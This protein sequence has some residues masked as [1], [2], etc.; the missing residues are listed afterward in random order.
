[1]NYQPDIEAEISF[2]S[3]NKGGRTQPVLS[4]YRPNHLI[5][6]NYLTSGE[7]NYID[8]VEVQPGEKSRAYIKFIAPEEYP[9]TLRVGTIINVQE[10]NRLIG[11]AK[12]L[13]IFNKILEKTIC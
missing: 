9:Y 4:G 7:H 13:K 1:M 11:Y 8:K 10:G 12:V 3:T 5:K 6:E 2:L